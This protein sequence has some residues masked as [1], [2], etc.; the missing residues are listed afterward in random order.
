MDLAGA[1]TL[2]YYEVQR[3]KTST[4]GGNSRPQKTHTPIALIPMGKSGQFGGSL[5]GDIW[6]PEED[7]TL[8]KLTNEGCD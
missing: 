2:L 6:R 3:W 4:E 1:V 7:D 5:C 8:M